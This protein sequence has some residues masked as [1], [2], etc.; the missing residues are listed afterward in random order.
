MFWRRDG[1][2][3]SARV[4]WLMA[5][6]LP[7]PAI[8][9]RV[10]A[11]CLAALASV[12]AGGCFYSPPS[13]DW[14]VSV[15][16]NLRAGDVG[17]DDLGVAVYIAGDTTDAVQELVLAYGAKARFELDPGTYTF[18]ASHERLAQT[19]TIDVWL[20]GRGGDLGCYVASLSGREI[21]LPSGVTSTYDPGVAMFGC[22]Y[23]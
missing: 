14:K 8:A 1:T 6:T 10:L 16:N 4:C 12:L 21:D 5:P 9:A 17:L 20:H 3:G 23:R 11:A 7:Q 19:L 2:R 18:V 22:E 13:G 15:A